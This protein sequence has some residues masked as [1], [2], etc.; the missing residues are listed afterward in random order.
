MKKKTMSRSELESM[1]SEERIENRKL[2]Y[3]TGGDDQG[4]QPGTGPWPRP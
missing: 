3:L 1:F 2:N 4:G